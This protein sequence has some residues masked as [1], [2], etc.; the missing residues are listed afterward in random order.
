MR[1][2][3]LSWVLYRPLHILFGENIKHGYTPSPC[4]NNM[5]IVQSDGKMKLS[6]FSESELV[7]IGPF[8]Y[9]G[10]WIGPGS[11]IP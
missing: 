7:K 3:T 6:R 4:G 11:N 9:I 8:S 10:I 2:V 1:L 5:S